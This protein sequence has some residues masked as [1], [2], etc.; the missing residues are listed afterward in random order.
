MSI[1]QY[2]RTLLTGGTTAAMDGISGASLADGD[3]C[4]VFTIDNEHYVYRLDAT[5]GASESSPLIITPDVSAGSKRWLLQNAMTAGAY[6]AGLWK[7][8][9]VGT[10]LVFY[11]YSSGWV[12][13]SRLEL[14]V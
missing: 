10:S 6:Y 1:M 12:E 4:D 14:P 11:Y 8:V 3:V 5:S 13:H 7:I 9:P 2:N